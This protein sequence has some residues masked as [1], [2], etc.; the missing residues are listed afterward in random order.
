M[1]G[2]M[3]IMYIMYIIYI[4]AIRWKAVEYLGKLNYSAEE[5]YGSK[6]RKYPIGSLQ[7]VSR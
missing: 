1:Y 6:S 4:N 3:Y 7:K 2:C 5:T